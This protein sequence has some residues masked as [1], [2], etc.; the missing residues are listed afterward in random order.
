MC[1]S[2]VLHCIIQEITQ[3]SIR[4]QYGYNSFE[5]NFNYLSLS[6]SPLHPGL[7]VCVC[8]C[9][10]VCCAL[11]VCHLSTGTHEGQKRVPGWVGVGAKMVESHSTWVLG[12]ELRSME[13]QQALFIA[14]PSLQSPDA[15][16]TSPRLLI[17]SRL[18][19][20]VLEGPWLFLCIWWD[21]ESLR[22]HHWACLYGLSRQQ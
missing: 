7:C 15:I 20:Q 11:S 14:D 8:V 19:V 12:T 9:V 17:N 5:K 16:K 3:Q 6:L 18:S 1:K 21:L 13:E 2:V 22:R 10:C 4:D